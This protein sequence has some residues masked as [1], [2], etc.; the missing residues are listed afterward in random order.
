MGR[1]M[2]RLFTAAATVAAIAAAAPA[3]AQDQKAQG[4]AATAAQPSAADQ[5]LCQRAVRHFASISA[6]DFSRQDR[7]SATIRALVGRL[8]TRDFEM[9]EQRQQRQP[10]IFLEGASS[11]VPHHDVL[12]LGDIAAGGH[13]RRIVAVWSLAYGRAA[14]SSERVLSLL[15]YR[16]QGA[17]WRPAVAGIGLATYVG[18]E[19]AAP[20]IVPLGE[21]YVVEVARDGASPQQGVADIARYAPVQQCFADVSASEPGKP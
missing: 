19:A 4:A 8:T 11:S 9:Y 7:A 5:R 18:P 14:R 1:E 20:R 3:T 6:G 12:V 17:T 16:L 13:K 2:M 21:G 10:A 15:E